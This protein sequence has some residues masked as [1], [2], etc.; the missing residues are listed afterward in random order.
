LAFAASAALTQTPSAPQAAASAA[1]AAAG[2][3]Q[4]RPLELFAALPH[5]SGPRLSPDG[6]RLAV[7]MRVQGQQV[8]AIVALNDPAARPANHAAEFTIPVLL[9]HGDRDVVVPVS[10][11][12]RM[13]SR[14][15]EAGKPHRYVEQRGGDHHF[16]RADDRLQFLREL[17]AFLDQHNPA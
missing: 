15:R 8:L 14:L 10:E 1:P 3:R 12:R 5:F 13:A 11:S 7:K 4:E 16:S 6:T 17:E 9:M 2:P